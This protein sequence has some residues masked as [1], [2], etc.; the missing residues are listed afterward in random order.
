MTAAAPDETD[1]FILAPVH[2]RNPEEGLFAHAAGNR[3]GRR[4]KRGCRSLAQQ[5]LLYEGRAG[6]VFQI[7]S[8]TQLFDIRLSPST[9]LHNHA[10]DELTE[11]EH[12]A[13][14]GDQLRDGSISQSTHFH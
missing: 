14:D 11:S 8:W 4:T 5:I 12:A 1:V 7:A 13:I 6:A 10:S 9:N 3:R 2:V